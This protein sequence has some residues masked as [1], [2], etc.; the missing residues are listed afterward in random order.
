MK[1]L[2][3][4]AIAF[5]AVILASCGGKKT[6]Q[7][8]AA[9]NEKSFEQ[10]QI[11]ASIKMHIDSIAAEIGQLKQFPF[12]QEGGLTLT[13]EE[14]QVKP[15]YLLNPSVAEEAAT[16]S[17]KY[18]ILSAL[19]V[20]KKIASLYEMPTDEYDKAIAKLTADINDPSFK[21][22]WPH[23]LFLATRFCSIGGA[24]LCHQPKCR[25]VPHRIRRQGCFQRDFPY[26]AD[27]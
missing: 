22:I 24:T 14:K 12:V 25:Q 27:S 26:R 17:E 18:R 1:K 19:S 9:Q 4:L 16:L 2:S 13:N 20:D 6:D 8:E 7:P 3:I 10:E 21:V 11:E 15:E 23:Q 5:A